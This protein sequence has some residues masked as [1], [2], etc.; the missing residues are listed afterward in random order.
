MD[1][2]LNESDL[3]GWKITRTSPMRPGVHTIH[4]QNEL[5]EE[6]VAAI[7]AML[8]KTL[9]RSAFDLLKE[10][11][12]P[13]VNKTIDYHELLNK[14]AD[15]LMSTNTE[16][17][18]KAVDA[19]HDMISKLKHHIERHFGSGGSNEKDHEEKR[20]VGYERRESG[21]KGPER[22]ANHSAVSNGINETEE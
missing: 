5:G 17:R 3:E 21:F 15:K 2:I 20:N 12:Q 8:H 22:R 19:H 6:K 7:S 4:L 10:D 13:K 1:K 16:E 11:F 14:H 18:A 9:R